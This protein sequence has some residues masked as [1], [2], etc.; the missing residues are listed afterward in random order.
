MISEPLS[1]T[2]LGWTQFATFQGDDTGRNCALAGLRA[3]DHNSA[4]RRTDT[5]FL[6]PRRLT[7]N[8]TCSVAFA[9]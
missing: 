6:K 8:Q 5:S 9:G 2:D 1:L 3:R 7:G 4:P